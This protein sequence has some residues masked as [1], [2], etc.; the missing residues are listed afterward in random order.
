ML[1]A[2]YEPRHFRPLS[3]MI[4]IRPGERGIQP[5]W[6]RGL[7]GLT[8]EPDSWLYEVEVG[9]LM[10]RC[11]RRTPALNPE[12]PEQEFRLISKSITTLQSSHV[13]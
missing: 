5:L 4:A 11:S 3:P 8:A 6:G 2:S 7:S 12:S 13:T 1:E 10:Y 9:V